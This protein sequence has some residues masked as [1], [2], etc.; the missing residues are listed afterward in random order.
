MF[1][2]HNSLEFLRANKISDTLVLLQNMMQILNHIDLFGN[3]YIFLIARL[4]VEELVAAFFWVLKEEKK[5]N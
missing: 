5:C 2:C 4:E 1:F 3:D